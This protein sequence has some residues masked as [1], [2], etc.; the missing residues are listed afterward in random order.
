MNTFKSVLTLSV[1]LVALHPFP[2]DNAGTY[3]PYRQ[4]KAKKHTAHF[5]SDMKENRGIGKLHR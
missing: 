3:V 4:C 5:K 2:Q 1:A